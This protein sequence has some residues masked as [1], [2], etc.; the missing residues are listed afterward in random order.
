VEACSGE[1]NGLLTYFTV[2]I[3]STITQILKMT[4]TNYSAE[5]PKLN[6]IT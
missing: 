2:E 1:V 6:A 3:T 5:N 4:D